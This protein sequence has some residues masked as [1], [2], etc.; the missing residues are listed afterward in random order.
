MWAFFRVWCL[1]ELAAALRGSKPAVMLVGDIDTAGEFVPITHMLSNLYNVVTITKATA[2][3]LEDLE[4]ELGKIEKDPGVAA[5]DSLVKGAIA[6]AEKIM[7]HP[8]VL[9]AACGQDKESMA[10]AFESMEKTQQND[11]LLA[12]SSAGFVEVV[13]SLVACGA[14]VAATEYHPDELWRG[15]TPLMEAAGGG[16]TAAIE[17]L[18]RL[19]ADINTADDSGFTALTFASVG[20]HVPAIELLVR[21]GAKVSTDDDSTMQPLEIALVNGHTA[22]AEALKR[23]GASPPPDFDSNSEVP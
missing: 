16:H 17:L 4:R 1:V 11:A 19:G 6:G 5:M 15:H 10:R 7:G 2:S 18:A 22:A 14:E 12:A 13:K 21:L 8:A 20:G 23:L 3:N 9:R